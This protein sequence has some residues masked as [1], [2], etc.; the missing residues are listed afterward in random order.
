[1]VFPVGK[2]FFISSFFFP[3]RF[4]LRDSPVAA[5]EEAKKKANTNEEVKKA[6]SNEEAKKK[7]RLARFAPASKT[8]TLE[9]EKRKARM[10]RY[11][12]TVNCWPTI[13]L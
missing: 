7:A 2:Y 13:Q 1:M 5:D 9:D 8:D 10:I 3:P 12:S 6:N 11:V 4:G